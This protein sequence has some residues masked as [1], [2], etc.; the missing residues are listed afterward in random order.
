VAWPDWLIAAELAERLGQGLGFDRLEDI[1]DEIEALAPA[2]RGCTRA[3]LDAPQSRDG[4]VVPLAPVRVGVGAA[5]GAN[6]TRPAPRPF[7][8]IATPGI[9]SV[10]VQG[11]P[12]RAGESVP[13]GV[14]GEPTGGGQRGSG[15]RPPLLAFAPVADPPAA[16]PL[17]GYSLRLVS[18][19]RLYDR[20]T[21]VSE[22]PSLAPLV[23]ALRVA[24]SLYDLDRLGVT[25]DEPVRVRSGRGEL[26]LPALADPALAHGVAVIDFGLAAGS[27]DEPGGGAGD[28]IDAS[29]PVVDVRLETI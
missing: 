5:Q 16:P 6:G 14:E 15:A 25:T 18:R 23:P 26:V 13:P 8:Q 7:D 29:L 27:E 28:L 9:E 19:R 2:F 11:A 10:E 24:A 21:A 17:D 20:G 3:V 22:S 1:T 12:L 4:V